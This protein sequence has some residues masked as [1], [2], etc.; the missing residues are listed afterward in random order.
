[1]MEAALTDDGRASLRRNLL[2]AAAATLAGGALLGF[3]AALVTLIDSFDSERA[4]EVVSE[5]SGF[6]AAGVFVAAL[7]LAAIAFFGKVPSRSSRLWM[8]FAL[9][10]LSLLLNAVSSGVATY[11]YATTDFVPG[12]G[13]AFNVVQATSYLVATAAAWIAA[14]A[15]LRSERSGIAVRDER[16]GWATGAGAGA[17]LL[18]GVA[19]ILELIFFSDLG[20]LSPL[21]AG[22]GV[23]AAGQ[24]VAV[25]AFVVAAV[26][27]FAGA[28]ADSVVGRS[29][30]DALVGIGAAVFAGAYLLVSIGDLI[31]SSSLSKNGFGGATIAAAW[32]GSVE[33]MAICGAAV[34]V[35]IAFMGTRRGT[36]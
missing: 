36:Q 18:A 3:V 17:F 19:R 8:A 24:F 25:A 27:F 10:A 32:L 12:T 4:S 35:A 33:S 15:Y 29:R 34:C 13:T 11:L 5:V 28:R 7:S 21:T 20:A 22:L 2:G 30:R 23:D 1:M 14:I 9:A 6:L 16:L 31:A 26:G